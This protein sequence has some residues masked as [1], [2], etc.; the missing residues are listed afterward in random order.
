MVLVCQHGNRHRYAI[1]RMLEEEGLLA[2]LYTDSTA[3]SILGKI[4]SVF[5]L[6]GLACPRTAAL[7][8]RRAEGVPRKKVFSSDRLF[9]A[10]RLPRLVSED[11]SPAW[12]RRGLQGARVIYNMSGEDWEFLN[13]AKGQGC[14]LIV[15][16]FVHPDTTRIVSDEHLRLFGEHPDD[17][18]MIGL[19]HE[20]YLR[21][22]ALADV[23]LCPSGWVAD[24]VRELYPEHAHKVRIVPYGNSL[25]VQDGG[26]NVPVPG[27]ILFAGR[28]P[29]RKGLHYLAKAASLLRAQGFEVDV[30]VAGVSAEELEWMENRDE[31][32]CLGS[33]PMDAMQAEFEAA[34][35]FVLPSLSEGQAS[36]ILEAMA[37]GCPVIA[38]R[39]SG[40][41][42]QEGSGVTVPSRDPNA[43]ARAI[44]D[45]VEDRPYRTRLAE[46][47]LRQAAE[48]SM[49]A[50]KDRLVNVVNETVKSQ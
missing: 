36:V 43:L 9:F 11:L 19:I 33:V 42:F 17:V 7:A 28:E 2:G 4:A 23:L 6:S 32:N 48:Y 24:G 10:A 18:A 15:D 37:C 8:A 21:T 49:E 39:E 16:I 26:S 46:G 22:F 34:D 31:L 29:M 3:Y 20:H 12:I 40:M 47:A 1:P 25:V 5:S 27:R 38:T 13:W 41:D 50:W 44:G 45:V 35:V 14:R 30:R